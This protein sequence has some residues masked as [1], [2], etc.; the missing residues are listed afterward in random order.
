MAVMLAKQRDA[1]R[2]R[3]VA[4][5][6]VTCS[7]IEITTATTTTTVSNNISAVANPSTDAAAAPFAAVISSSVEAAHEP[8]EE[9][10]ANVVGPMEQSVR[11]KVT[12]H[13]EEEQVLIQIAQTF[14]ILDFN[15]DK[16]IDRDEFKR[17]IS[18][19][20]LHRPKGAADGWKDDA[21]DK[22]DVD[23]KGF[24]HF[25][26]FCYAIA[27]TIFT[28]RSEGRTLS[29]IECLQEVLEATQIAQTAAKAP[30][31]APR[32]GSKNEYGIEEQRKELAVAAEVTALH[33][34]TRYDGWYD[35]WCALLLVG[36]FPCYLC[37]T[38]LGTSHRADKRKLHGLPAVVSYITTCKRAPVKYT[39]RFQNYHVRSESGNV[40]Y[41]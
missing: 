24:I 13:A 12:G 17:S 11:R 10:P 7:N 5:R 19:L 18:R 29:A 22:F 30:I 40:L 4:K 2:A 1:A 35:S 9:R 23:K 21:F 28:Y 3:A 8:V 20:D 37:C 15:D 41:I 14:D 16:K 25:G 6:P 26:E 33:E 34:K 32:S 36:L 38:P 27:Q 39:W 31:P